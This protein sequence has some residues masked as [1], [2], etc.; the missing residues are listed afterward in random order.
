MKRRS[1]SFV[2]LGLATA[3]L[4]LSTAAGVAGDHR[5]SLADAPFFLHLGVSA[6]PYNEAATIAIDG[7][8]V[9]GADVHLDPNY[10]L[11]VEAGWYL[12]PNFAIS[13]S[14][15][16]PPTADAMAAGSIAAYGSLGKVTGGMIELNGQYHFTNF[17]GFQPYVGAG[18][19]FF[20]VFDTQDGTL[21][22]FSVKDSFGFNLQVGADWMI[23]KNVGLFVDLKKIFISTSASGYLGTSTVT[24]D[25]RLDPMIFSVGMA[26]R[27]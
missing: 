19:T 8:T 2:V 1:N 9:P 7:Y 20:H 13:L 25:V 17:G 21:A 18:P 15:G 12:T 14:S 26:L 5:W 16:Y 11:A 10:T 6:V 23:T 24:S 22:A 3:L 4:G 27:Y